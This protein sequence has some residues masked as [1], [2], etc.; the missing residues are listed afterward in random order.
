MLPHYRMGTTGQAVL[1]QRL[2]HQTRGEVDPTCLSTRKCRSNG[3]RLS[4]L[5]SQV[6]SSYHVLALSLGLIIV[7]RTHPNN[8][9]RSP[10]RCLTA[11]CE[12]WNT[13]LRCSPP[14][15]SRIP[16]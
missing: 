4:V 8:S 16:A 13:P 11:R 6:I 1:P 12:G 5:S 9:K 10:L 14:L 3:Y 15:G 2:D 7:Y